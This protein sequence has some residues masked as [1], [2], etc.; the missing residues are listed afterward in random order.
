[1]EPGTL[2]TMR[3]GLKLSQAELAAVLGVSRTAL[4]MWENG[5]APIPQK[6]VQTIYE[7]C[8]SGTFSNTVDT[9]LKQTCNIPQA[10]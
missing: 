1:M 6:A 8:P 4:S 7:L 3:Q 10:P 2:V 9:F 5:H